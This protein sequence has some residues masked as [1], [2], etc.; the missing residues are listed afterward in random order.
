MAAVEA[1][2]NPESWYDTVNEIYIKRRRIADSIMDLLRCKFDKNQT[3][4]FV[5]GRIPETIP[6]CETYVEEIL[7]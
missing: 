7:E 2:N 3:G 1:L 6:D 4:L 5:W